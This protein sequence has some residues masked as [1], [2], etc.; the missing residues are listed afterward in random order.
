MSQLLSF[1]VSDQILLWAINVLIH[2]TVLA[3]ISLLIALLFRKVAVTRYWILCLGMLL[4]LGS[5]LISA[6]IQSRGDSFLT[7]ALPVEEAADVAAPTPTPQIV[8]EMPAPERSFDLDQPIESAPIGRV[9]MEQPF[10]QSVPTPV[11]TPIVAV[12]ETVATPSPIV[13]ESVAN[14]RSA[15][16]W[17]RVLL[18]SALVVWALG[19]ILLL[20]RMSFGWTHVVRILKQAQPVENAELR[21]AFEQAC[22]AVGHTR[23]IEPKFVVSDAVSGPI[24][25]G[26]F[27]GTV[28]LPRHLIDQ[29][30]TANLANVLVHEVAHVA[31]RD[32]IV[33]LIQNLVAA[34]YWPHPLVKMLNRELAKAREEVC[35]N[36]VLAG[37]EAPAYSRTLL[38]L[39]E[40][41]QQPEA[42]PGSV[43]FFTDRWKLE[44]RVAGLLD[45]RRDRKTILSKRSWMCLATTTVLLAVMTCVSTI[46]FATATPIDG[47]TLSEAENSPPAEDEPVVI[48]GVVSDP[49]GK[50]VSGA[51]VVAFRH[52]FYRRLSKFDHD[53]VAETTSDAKGEYTLQLPPPSRKFSNGEDFGV[54]GTSVLA[55]YEGFGPEKKTVWPSAKSVDLQLAVAKVPLV[56]RVLDLEGK[57]VV[58]ARVKLQQIKKPQVDFG[59]TDAVAKW[60]ELAKKNPT[61]NSVNRKEAVSANESPAAIVHFYPEGGRLS[62]VKL[63]NIETTTD[64]DGRFR[65]NDIGDDRL[66]VLRVD[67][68]DVAS[69]MLRVVARKMAAVNAPRSY[70]LFRS[71][72][73][74]GNEPV[75]IAEPSRIVRG[76]IRDRESG[77]PIS[78]ATVSLTKVPLDLFVPDS[79]G[80]LSATS[81]AQGRYELS[82]L[83]KV[84]RGEKRSI[85]LAIEPPRRALETDQAYF[86]S[87]QV[88][89]RAEGFEPIKFDIALT[90]GVWASGQV[91]DSKTGDPVPSV[92]GYH[93]VIDNQNAADH[94][95]FSAGTLTVGDDEMFATD[96]DGNFYVPALKGR[97]VLRVIA[98][99]LRDYEVVK[100]PGTEIRESGAV[101]QTESKIYHVVSPGNAVVDLNIAQDAKQAQVD[102]ELQHLDTL[103]LK[104]LNPDGSAASGFRVAGRHDTRSVM[105]GGNYWQYKTFQD[106]TVEVMLSSQGKLDRPVML[107]NRKQ[108]LGAVVWPNE[109]NSKNLST[110][111]VRLQPCATIVGTVLNPGKKKSGR[112]SIQAGIGGIEVGA[113]K[114]F[115]YMTSGSEI[116]DEIGNFEYIVPPSDH[117]SLVLNGRETL[118]EEASLAPGE[119]LNL[120]TI[121]AKADPKTWPKPIRTLSSVAQPSSKP[122]GVV[123]ATNSE[124]LSPTAEQTA[125]RFAGRVVN[126]DGGPIEGA[127]LQLCG[128]TVGQPGALSEVL[129]VSGKDGEFSFERPMPA[130]NDIKGRTALKYSRLVASKDG[131]GVAVTRAAR[132]ET[133]GQLK[134]LLNKE[135]QRYMV[136]EP[137]DGK[138][139]AL[140]MPPDKNRIRGRIMNA[141]GQPVVGAVV[142][143]IRMSE[144]KASTLDA[145]K[146]ET[147]RAG[148]NF[149][150]AR[151]KLKTVTSGSFID[152]PQTTA[153]AAIKTDADGHFELR[154]LGDDRIAELIVSCDSIETSRIY[155]RSEDG[156]TIELPEDS[157][158]RKSIIQTYYP[159]RF[160]FVAG[161]TRPVVG[162]LLDHE[163]G[164]PVA[165]VTVEGYRTPH[166]TGGSMTA[167]AVNAVSA[168]D[169]SFRL[170]GLPIGKSELRIR[171]P[172]D[173]T[174]MVGG[175]QITTRVQD[176]EVTRDVAMRKGVIQR[177]R[178]VETGTDIPVIGYF[179]YWPMASNA[180]V[181]ETP[182]LKRGDQRLRYFV[183]AEGNFEIPVLPG[184]G[185]LTFSADDDKRFQRGAGA[186]AI[187]WPTMPDFNGVMYETRPY[188]LM[189]TNFHNLAPIE[190]EPGQVPNPMDIQMDPGVSIPIRITGVDG[191][192]VTDVYISGQRPFGGW[193]SSQYD[194][195]LLHGYEPNVGRNVIIYHPPSESMAAISLKGKAPESLEMKL[196]PSGR[197]TGRLVN[198]DGDP[199]QDAVINNASKNF[200][201]RDDLDSELSM[202]PGRIDGKPLLTDKDGRFSI[203]GL[204]PGKKY[205]AFAAE[206]SAPRNL[207]I[208]EIFNDLKVEAGQTTDIG[209]LQ[210]KD[211]GSFKA[212]NIP[213]DE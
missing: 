20:V 93:P 180:A 178:I 57:P 1:V 206:R 11:E 196:V 59:N 158:G 18:T 82:G 136:D 137:S 104:V 27:G 94:E 131:F 34:L 26:I 144:G 31:R 171:P 10:D 17:L 210:L 101:S 76:I 97:G 174:Y 213:L 71:E 54:A 33:V 167:R 102:V 7:L 191:S 190:L 98:G 35:D 21:Q 129:A 175:I 89:P 45:T 186:K 185:I 160:T 85:S 204:L 172:A 50:R 127:E 83:P 138:P 38:S 123:R 69:M 182:M 141:D 145:W 28:V 162:R 84:G 154:G 121:D 143:V 165:G 43:G 65:I 146:K 109:I 90:R 86:R 36:F 125:L 67:G 110:L 73:T 176:K 49:D 91:T 124:D 52:I 134:S 184:R 62:G 189:P 139:L 4:V 13:T 132:A 148:A 209:T 8:A 199:I 51:R 47:L 116:L 88:V 95:A 99:K 44:H 66:A 118:L 30:D 5:P 46:T 92:V 169:G 108:S 194:G 195:L 161:E 77:D 37:I 106:S 87:R 41:V 187:S 119:T 64:T 153:L 117:Y 32:Q 78:G 42:M 202:F 80:F 113:R 126:K 142:A 56:G 197:V 192:P 63:L 157:N 155:A 168:V 200:Q 60:V 103:V 68:A 12:N 135:E 112:A 188:F 179:Q 105:Q 53:L 173:S 2:T 130:S 114:R 111:E 75:V 115:E 40:L 16:D 23:A 25:A 151:E 164:E 48:K 55:M 208:G 183:D 133:T 198:P 39:A 29:V 70:G 100:L 181:A 122:V 211:D 24:A 58:G 96:E 156:E 107:F 193:A 79:D 140:V 201:A 128:A 149:Y 205:S 152:G 19:T 159:N 212:I 163:T 72:K 15:S 207:T 3:A 6:F 61:S 81:D 177:G 22:A 147:K 203:G 120:G 170:V 166:S 150:S 9:E 14:A 74:Y